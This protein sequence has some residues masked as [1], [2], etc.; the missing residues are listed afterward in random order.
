MI[1]VNTTYKCQSKT[2]QSQKDLKKKQTFNSPPKWTPEIASNELNTFHELKK[3]KGETNNP[4]AKVSNF[5]E[6]QTQLNSKLVTK[7]ILDSLYQLLYFPK[8]PKKYH[9]LRSKQI[10]GWERSKEK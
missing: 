10:Q 5:P 4:K 2:K 3:K 1:Q 6:L 9:I 7:Y 8:Q